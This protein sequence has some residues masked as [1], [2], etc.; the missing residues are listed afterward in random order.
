MR[1]FE[2]APA[3]CAQAVAALL[4]DPAL[5]AADASWLLAVFAGHVRRVTDRAT[6]LARAFAESAS[7][8]RAREVLRELGALGEV[9]AIYVLVALAREPRLREDGLQAIEAGAKKAARRSR[10][11]GH[12]NFSDFRALVEKQGTA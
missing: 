5:E 3:A 10:G 11:Y 12:T 1:V 2:S 7:P 4:A 9:P 6:L 8:E